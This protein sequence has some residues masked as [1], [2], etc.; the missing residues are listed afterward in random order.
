MK[1]LLILFF[2][3]TQLLSQHRMAIDDETICN[4]KFV[5]AISETLHTLPINKIITELGKTFIGTPYEAN[6]LEVKETESLIINLR[7]LD[8][9]SFYENTLALARCIKQKKYSFDEYKKELQLIRYRNGKIDGYSSRLHYTSDYFYNNQ[10]KGILKLVTREVAPID[11]VIK[12]PMPLDYMTTHRDLY[13]G[14]SDNE[15]FAKMMFFEDILSKRNIY[16]LPKV[17]LKEFE[18]NILSGDILGFTTNVKGLDVAHT[19]IAYR[20]EDGILKLL[21]APNVG[22]RVSI[23]K[24]SLVDYIKNNSKFTGLIIARAVNL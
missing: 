4:E 5:F 6:T 23:T 19:G 8:C 15:Q 7:V 12:I 18:A 22:E 24:Q 9:V 14:L 11:I 13:N 16:Y 17:E 10:E 2:S 20:D 1:V 3:F 21:H